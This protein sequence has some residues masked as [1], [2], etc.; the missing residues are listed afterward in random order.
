MGPALFG[1]FW[2]YWQLAGLLCDVW[3]EP[4]DDLTALVEGH[5]PAFSAASELFATR[6]G[7]ASD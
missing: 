7:Q 3:S 1:A 6:Y 4:Q 2:V 5:L